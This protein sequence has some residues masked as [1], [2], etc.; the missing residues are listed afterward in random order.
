MA[1]TNTLFNNASGS[2]TAASGAGP[3]TALF[4]TAASYSGSVFTLDGTPNLSG[5]ATDGS[6]V[7]WVQTS[8]GRQFFTINAVDDGANTVT[9]DDAPAGTTTGLT[10]GLGGKRQTV[11]NTDSRLLFSTDAKAGWTITL[12]DD[13]PA[14]TS[15][16]VCTA[17][18]DTTNGPIIFQGDSTTAHH[19]LTS[20][21]NNT[22]IS[23]RLR[24]RNQRV[25][26]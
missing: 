1:T 10:W 3:T 5:V 7:I 23:G 24:G 9:V 22:S 15:V 19:L 21:T 11:G 20:A 17:K 6:H 16:L 25:A 13:Q 8:T 12:E 26:A 2:D 18:G 4:G 14:L